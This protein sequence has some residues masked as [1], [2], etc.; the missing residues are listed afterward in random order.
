MLVHHFPSVTWWV[1]AADGVCGLFLNGW[2]LVQESTE[3]LPVTTR[4]VFP[5]FISV[6]WGLMGRNQLI[7]FC[8]MSKNYNPIVCHTFWRRSFLTIQRNFITFRHGLILPILIFCN[9]NIYFRDN[10][11]N[12]QCFTTSCNI[13]FILSYLLRYLTS[14]FQRK[15]FFPVSAPN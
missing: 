9:L 4:Q 14:L 7:K 3:W 13:R 2:A 5:V 8:W 1:S 15:F 6:D 12:I 11:Q 10:F